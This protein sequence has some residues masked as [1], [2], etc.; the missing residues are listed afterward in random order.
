MLNVK[1]ISK[2]IYYQHIYKL[3][4]NVKIISR[5]R[6]QNLKY[7]TYTININIFICWN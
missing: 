3:M 4:F 2:T 6:G 1:N 5:I 7:L